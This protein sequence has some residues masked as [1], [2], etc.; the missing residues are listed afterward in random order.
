MLRYTERVDLKS[1]TQTFIFM[2][3]QELKYYIRLK[4]LREYD[5]EN[6]PPI[7]KSKSTIKDLWILS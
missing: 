6:K 3:N 2:Y 1:N 5:K 7:K 4:Q